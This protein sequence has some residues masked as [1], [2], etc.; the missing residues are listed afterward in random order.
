[1]LFKITLPFYIP[2]SI[3]LQRFNKLLLL[4]LNAKILILTYLFKIISYFFVFC[5]K[6]SKLSYNI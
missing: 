4:F 6:T 2:P 5:C 3:F 1:M